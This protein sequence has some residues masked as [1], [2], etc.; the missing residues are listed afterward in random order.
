V[1]EVRW[2]AKAFGLAVMAIKLD[3]ADTWCSKV[4]RQK[5]NWTCEYSGKSDGRMECCHIYGR[6]N[7]SVRWSLDNL[8]CLS[9]YQHRYFTEN[10]TEFTAWLETYLGKGHMEMLKEKKNCLMPTTKKLRA[11]IAKHY[12]EEFKKMEADPSYTPVSYN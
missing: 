6:R 9:H 3:A 2:Q 5:A 11:E 4:V 12:R 1:P 10:P 7:K 8:V